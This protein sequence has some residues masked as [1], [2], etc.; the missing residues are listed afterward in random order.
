MTNKETY[1][2]VQNLL[3]EIQ[4]YEDKITALKKD[5]SEIRSNCRH[6]TWTYSG[7][8]NRTERRRCTRCAIEKDTGVVA[9]QAKTI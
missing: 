5:L 6:V 2:Y 8:T 9:L 3:M 4:S 7:I 1:E